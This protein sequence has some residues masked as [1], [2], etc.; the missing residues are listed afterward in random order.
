M[1]DFK[2]SNNIDKVVDSIIKKRSKKKL[3]DMEC[4][5]TEVIK[6]N[7]IGTIL[8]TVKDG[9]I[10][11]CPHCCVLTIL[12]RGGYDNDEG[13]FSCGCI[14]RKKCKRKCWFCEVKHAHDDNNLV[15]LNYFD[16]INEPHRLYGMFACSKC[17]YKN[18]YKD[19]N[20]FNLS[21]LMN[22]KNNNLR[23][24][25]MYGGFETFMTPDEYDEYRSRFYKRRKI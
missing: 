5:N 2:Y 18:C 17:M 6:I 10:V 16:D 22:I 14:K 8:C 11:L 19:R 1:I 4:M 23:K 7:M 3:I 13:E 24:V 9:N 21:E 12:S 20:I 15:L 25:R